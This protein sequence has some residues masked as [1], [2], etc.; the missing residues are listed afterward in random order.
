VY[1]ERAG[2]D[3]TSA[4]NCGNYRETGIRR[5]TLQPAL[6]AWQLVQSLLSILRPHGAVKM[7]VKTE[8]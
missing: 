6:G 4:P 2:F 7:L 5:V 8:T 1:D 3:R